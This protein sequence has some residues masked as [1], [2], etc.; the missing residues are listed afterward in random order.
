MIENSRGILGRGG[1]K[2]DAILEE[3]FF[4]MAIEQ[5]AGGA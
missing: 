5:A 3:A 2:K 1:W 4:Q